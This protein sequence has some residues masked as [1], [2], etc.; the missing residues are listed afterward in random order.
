MI[1]GTSLAAA[2]NKS[3]SNNPDKRLVRFKREYSRLLVG[4]G[5][6]SF[7][8]WWG[9]VERVTEGVQRAAKSDRVREE[10]RARRGD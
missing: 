8:W 3:T 5:A 9:E 10:G 6:S 2:G 1:A 7:V 4:L